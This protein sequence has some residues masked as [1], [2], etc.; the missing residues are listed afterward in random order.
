MI[1]RYL[2]KIESRYAVMKI[3]RSTSQCPKVQQAAELCHRIV[4]V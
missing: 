3:T 4:H 2:S 1:D